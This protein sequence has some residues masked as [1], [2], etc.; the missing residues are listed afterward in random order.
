MTGKSAI[1]NLGTLVMLERV[2]KCCYGNRKVSANESMVMIHMDDRYI[3]Q[4]LLLGLMLV[5]PSN[6]SYVN[7]HAL[8]WMMRGLRH[9]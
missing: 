5:V 2:I 4:A 8:R 9:F 7:P 6:R 3:Q 1:D